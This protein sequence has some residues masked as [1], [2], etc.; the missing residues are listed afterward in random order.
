MGKE[1]EVG[2]YKV[3]SIVSADIV[4]D[5]TEGVEVGAYQGCGQKGLSLEHIGEKIYIVKVENLSGMA[6]GG[7]VA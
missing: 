1:A 2:A 6:E 7:A 3:K 5:N 4:E